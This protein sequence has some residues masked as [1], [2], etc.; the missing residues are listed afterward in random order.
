MRYV[1]LGDSITA[2]RENVKVYFEWLQDRK[3]ELFL[4]EMINSGVRGW[5]SS[6]L[7]ANLEGVCLRYDPDIVTIMIGTNDHAIYQGNELP[8][9]SVV[10]FE[11]NL[12]KIVRTIR[13]RRTEGGDRHI[14]KII[15]MT[16]PFVATHTN[17]AGTQAS[18]ARL[19]EYCRAIKKI[20]ERENTG[21]VDVNVITG[22]EVGWDDRTFFDQ[23][24]DRND[25]VHLNSLGHSVIAPY[26]FRAVQTAAIELRRHHSNP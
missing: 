21:F 16:P 6:D 5:K 2:F 4:T 7:L 19:T 9:I 8:A 14:P 13:G 18:Q 22:N 17:V 24:T 25:G 11:A 1:A 3:D 10:D 15:L 23:Y 26:I 12:T 20:S